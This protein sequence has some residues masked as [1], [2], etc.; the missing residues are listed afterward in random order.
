MFTSYR[1][2]V[3]QVFLQVR[4]FSTLRGATC[5]KGYKPR[6]VLLQWIFMRFYGILL[7]SG[8]YYIVYIQFC[9]LVP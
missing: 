4:P 1:L 6:W 5:Q 9:S 7:G 3:L 2:N 8:P